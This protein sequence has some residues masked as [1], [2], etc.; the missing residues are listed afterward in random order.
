MGDLHTSDGTNYA[1][2][3]GMEERIKGLCDAQE[4]CEQHH[5]GLLEQLEGQVKSLIAKVDHQG[6]CISRLSAANRDHRVLFPILSSI[7]VVLNVIFMLLLYSKI[8]AF[9]AT[10]RA[11]EARVTSMDTTASY[12]RKIMERR[13]QILEK[14]HERQE[15]NP[16]LGR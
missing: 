14:Y 10:A 6:Q 3:V 9:D 5:T 2:I 8:E 1:A 11:L 15:T 4:R 16:R 12:E 13:L 7:V